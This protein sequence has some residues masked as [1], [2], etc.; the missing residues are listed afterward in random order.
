M[1]PSAYKRGV[2][3]YAN[4]HN[5]SGLADASPHYLI[6]MLMDGFLARVNAAKGA[7]DRSDL[8]LKSVYISRA[9][10]IVGGLNEAVD[11]EKGGEIAANLSRLYNYM[12]TRL[13][14]AS[15]ENDEAI[16]DEVASLMR[17][18]KGAWD[19]IKN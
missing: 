3:Q 7:M 19:A 2:N 8:E 6:Q 4:V 5:E 14:Q 11:L 17:E 10:A 16:L 13:L 15:R 12:T 9:V 18:I 1:Y